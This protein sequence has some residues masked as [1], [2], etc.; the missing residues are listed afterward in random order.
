MIK[1]DL[2]LFAAAVLLLAGGGFAAFG[3]NEVGGILTA[4]SLL[5]FLAWLGAIFVGVGEEVE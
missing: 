4:S 2:L 1:S 5:S 3:E